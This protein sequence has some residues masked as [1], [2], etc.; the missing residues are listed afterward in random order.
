MC[1]SVFDSRSLKKVIIAEGEQ[2]WS[3]FIS[4]LGAHTFYT[5]APLCLVV[6]CRFT[7]DPKSKL[8][9][10]PSTGQ[11]NLVDVEELV[12]VDRWLLLKD[13]DRDGG[14]DEE[15]TE[16]AAGLEAKPRT[17]KELLDCVS[18]NL[19]HL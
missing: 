9:S 13:S 12:E 11:Q 7:L 18:F 4:K 15:S 1:R 8:A 10:Q 17:G 3:V 5:T 16:G 14:A 2:D 6:R 19:P